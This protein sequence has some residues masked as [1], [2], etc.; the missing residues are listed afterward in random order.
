MKTN[1]E[2]TWLGSPRKSGC[3]L[4]AAP[5][6]LSM[7]CFASGAGRFAPSQ[8]FPWQNPRKMRKTPSEKGF[9]NSNFLG[10]LWAFVTPWLVLLK[11]CVPDFP[12]FYELKLSTTIK[13]QQD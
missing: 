1:R 11:L 12:D 3:A 13:Q 7:A 8:A 2:V 5:H 6:T 9:L 4:H 10:S